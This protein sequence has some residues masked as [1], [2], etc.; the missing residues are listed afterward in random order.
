MSDAPPPLSTF[1]DPWQRIHIACCR[2]PY[3]LEITPEDAIATF[4][5]DMTIVRLKRIL[6]CSACGA[7]GR[8]KDI[9]VYPNTQDYSDWIDR[10]EY[11]RH[12]ERWGKEAADH[13]WANRGVNMLRQ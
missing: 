1:L 3:K 7:R 8:E 4:G 13:L 10:R 2:C 9:S 6:K 11:D 5:A 12:V